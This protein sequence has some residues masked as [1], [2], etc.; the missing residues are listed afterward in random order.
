[1]LGL[2][3]FSCGV[4]CAADALRLLNGDSFEIVITDPELPDASGFVLCEKVKQAYPETVVL[5][6]AGTDDKLAA[7]EAARNGA[8][9]C[10]DRSIQSHQLQEIV[11]QAR[12]QPAT[13]TGEQR[14]S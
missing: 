12:S 11:R 10:L 3:W 9:A 14:R 1:M 7:A 13:K 8:F 2:E 4:K 5:I 6:Y